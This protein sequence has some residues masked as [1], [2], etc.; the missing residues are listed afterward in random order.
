MALVGGDAPAL[1]RFANE[2]RQRRASIEATTQ[3]L[4]ALV[5]QATWV[6]ADR[7]R[8]MSEWHGRHAPALLGV[9]RELGDAANQIAHHATQQEQASRSHG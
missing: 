7:D 4:G 9:V 8:F 2:L 1:F 3:R 6:G 5:E